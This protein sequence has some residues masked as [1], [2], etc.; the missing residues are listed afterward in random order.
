[1]KKILYLFLTLLVSFS[2]EKKI[3]E[4]VPDSKIYL[5]PESMNI[6]QAGDSAEVFLTA[7]K[8]WTAS[9]N[10]DW[11]KISKT[12][13]EAIIDH[14]IIVLAIDTN[15]ISTNRVAKVTFVCDGEIATVTINQLQK[16]STPVEVDKDTQE[17]VVTLISDVVV[18]EIKSNASWV[19]YDPNNQENLQPKQYRLD[20]EALGEHGGI[21]GERTATVSFLN[22]KDNLLE[23]VVI[24]Q[25]EDKVNITFKNE[26][27]TLISS[28]L[29]GFNSIYSL[30][31][32]AFWVDT[33]IKDALTQMGTH[34]LRWPGG[35]P[36]NRY[37][38]DNLNGYG[39]I[40]SWSGDTSILP[41]AGYT[42]LDEHIAICKE[43]GATSLI[44]INQGS[45]LEYNRVDDGI[46]EAKALVK[47]CIDK[48]YNVNHY[49]LD[50]EPYHA[51]ANYKMTW[52][53]YA[54]QINLYAPEIKKINPDAKIIINWQRIQPNSLWEILAAAGDNIDI[55]EIHW[56]WKHGEATF[57]AWKDELPM[58]TINKWYSQG[59]TYKEEIKYFYA[60]CVELGYTHIELGSL[61]WNVGPIGGTDDSGGN[62]GATTSDTYPTKYE[63]T[64]MQAEMLMQF[65]DGGLNV[66]TMWPIFWPDNGGDYN[67]NRY[68]MDPNENYALS[69]SVDMFTMLS[70]AQGKYKYEA[71]SD[72]NEGEKR[73]YPLVVESEDKKTMIV[74]SHSKATNGRWINFKAPKYANVI[75]QVLKPTSSTNRDTGKKETMKPEDIIYNTNNGY[76]RYY[77]P[78]YSLGLLKLSNAVEEETE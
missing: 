1:M 56:Y 12:E 11:I 59:L 69:P 35:A 22:K 64:I 49:Y 47:Y 76:Y 24:N 2:C 5:L 31:S 15:K 6:V 40:D 36:T 14:E 33:K 67:P 13:G 3:D 20:I 60:K 53:E 54:D 61:E 43:I 29:I 58:N 28:S 4:I 78:A 9:T 18:D 71:S 37:H 8:K 21:S 74:Y 27:P 26:N 45:G 73:I 16:A 51:G 50:N 39:W 63:N 32:D 72:E 77:L 65:I 57:D 68:L 42:D 75:Y 23:T 17:K 52:Q 41:P 70:E 46:A 19:K 48:E 44:G 62:D 38:W 34:F 30:Y 10:V 66:A 7:N 25:S 55:V